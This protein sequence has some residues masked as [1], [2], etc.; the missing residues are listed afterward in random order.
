MEIG[1]GD[2]AN[3]LRLITEY[4][5]VKVELDEFKNKAAV[6]MM[7]RTKGV[8]LEQGGR[9]TKYFLSLEKKKSAERTINMIENEER[10]YIVGDINIL[11]FSKNHFEKVHLSK[12][13]LVKSIM[14][15][16]D[17]MELDIPVLSDHNKNQC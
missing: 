16:T 5:E 17:G 1:L 2:N 7:L 12:N 6:R 13:I 3:D 15:F 14:A 10:N 9:L 8:W 4:A 11:N